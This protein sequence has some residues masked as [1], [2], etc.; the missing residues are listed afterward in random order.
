MNQNSKKQR[1]AITAKKTAKQARKNSERISFGG[2]GATFSS[3]RNH[4][5]ESFSPQDHDGQLHRSR[6]ISNPKNY[7]GVP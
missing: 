1:T 5:T 4:E 7:A 3:T 6:G 2:Q